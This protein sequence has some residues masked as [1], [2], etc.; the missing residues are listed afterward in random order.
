MLIIKKKIDSFT[1]KGYGSHHNNYFC[2]YLS[3]AS[4][5][6]FT[7]IEEELFIKRLNISMKEYKKKN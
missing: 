1:F 4:A 7:K 5:L 2:N 3:S 6:G